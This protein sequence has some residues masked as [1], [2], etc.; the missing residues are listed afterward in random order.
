M[1]GAEVEIHTPDCA[2]C[3]HEALH[4]LERD[5]TSGVLGPALAAQAYGV[6]GDALAAHM[7]RCRPALSAATAKAGTVAARREAVVVTPVNLA[8]LAL[9][10]LTLARRLVW[11]TGDDAV[12]V[13]G[14]KIVAEYIALARETAQEARAWQ[15]K[16]EAAAR[17]RDLERSRPDADM[18]A[19][20]APMGA[21]HGSPAWQRWAE[22]HL[23]REV[24][25]KLER[26]SVDAEAAR[27]LT[28]EQAAEL[29][30]LYLACV[31]ADAADE[32]DPVQA[33]RYLVEETAARIVTRERAVELLGPGAE[34]WP[35][36]VALLWYLTDDEDD[37]EAQ[38][39][40]E[41]AAARIAAAAIEH[42]AALDVPA[43]LA[44]RDVEAAG[45]TPDALAV[46]E[47]AA[48]KWAAQ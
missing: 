46:V 32:A 30:R 17:R 11:G 29:S 15:R 47:T 31:P 20:T 28:P 38:A 23:R 6:E 4:M 5:V 42:A 16:E 12:R 34:R 24:V 21:D 37:A 35:L 40:A 8:A 10:G 43:L 48:A 41:R 39:R 26:L 1:P 22:N 36:P 7:E 27:S 33:R 9:E 25:A 45:I 19:D 3:G 44:R 2:V 13:A 18:W 14:L